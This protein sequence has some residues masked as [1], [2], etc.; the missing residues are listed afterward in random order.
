VKTNLAAENLPAWGQRRRLPSSTGRG[1]SRRSLTKGLRDGRI[2]GDDLK[3]G[4]E[5]MRA[6]YD[7]ALVG[8]MEKYVKQWGAKVVRE[9]M[10][11]GEGFV[12]AQ[13]ERPGHDTVWT[14]QDNDGK[15]RSDHNDTE[16]ESHAEMAP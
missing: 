4:G 7:R 8:G 10:P 6:F 14:V 9:N 2:E 12:V 15:I 3:V 13:I 16:A 11:L 1:R 5:G